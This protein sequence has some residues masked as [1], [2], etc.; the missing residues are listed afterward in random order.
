MI[1]KILNASFR[2]ILL[3]AFLTPLA[4]DTVVEV[5]AASK[6]T[7]I[8]TLRSEL[9]AL[10]AEKTASENKQALTKNQIKS[11]QNAAITAENNQEANKQKI[12]KAEEDIVANEQETEKV[13]EETNEL[14][15][16]LQMSDSQNALLEYVASAESTTDLIVRSAVVEQLTQYN[17]E[18]LAKLAK[19]IEDNK[20]LKVELAEENEQL[21]KNI[22]N[23]NA[24]AS[25]LG[26]ELAAISDTYADINTKIKSQESTIAYYKKICNNEDQ[27]INTCG[28]SGIASAYGWVKPMVT[29]K[30]NSPYGPR[31]GGFHK[32][33]D[34]GGVAEGTP[35]YAT[36]TGRVSMVWN[37]SSCGGNV[38]FINHI[39]NGKQYT[40]EYAH[41]LF[42]SVSIGQTVT[43]STQIG[44]MGGGSTQSYDAC[45]TGKHLH[46]AVNTGHYYG[47]SGDSYRSWST[48]SNRHIQPP[49]FP[50]TGQ[51]FYTR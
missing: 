44:G 5:N 37:R 25:K 29:A 15:R 27:D 45:T 41:L 11:N 39:V 3:I 8:K 51:W 2:I 20:K 23:Y 28:T 36:A 33:I 32:G 19:L 42:I 21:T 35:V 40:T 38:V 10:Y 50:K 9:S 48:Y 16:F 26:D 18:Q 13:K 24:A 17:D 34:L 31:S 1:K 6:V 14:L 43:T 12:A 46:Y 4:I 22:A 49:G 30:V 7:T 47:T